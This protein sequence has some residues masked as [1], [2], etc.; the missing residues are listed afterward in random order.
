M[1]LR[2]EIRD[3]KNPRARGQRFSTEKRARQEMS[4]IYGA[5]RGRYQLI[6]RETKRVLTVNRERW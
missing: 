6:D 3:T 5:P 4:Q 1:A 2:Y